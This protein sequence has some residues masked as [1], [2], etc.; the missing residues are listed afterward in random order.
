MTKDTIFSNKAH[1][2]WGQVAKVSI[3]YCVLGSEFK[4]YGW[5]IVIKGLSIPFQILESVFFVLLGIEMGMIFL[6]LPFIFRFLL[7]LIIVQI[8]HKWIDR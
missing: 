7:L 2:L 4:F 3:A 1:P 6:N 8:F 5:G